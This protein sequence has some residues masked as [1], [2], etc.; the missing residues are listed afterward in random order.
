M[1]AKERKVNTNY[2]HE[3]WLKC[4]KLCIRSKEWTSM[5]IRNLQAH[6]PIH[7]WLK[8]AIVDYKYRSSMLE[9]S[10]WSK[11]RAT[12]DG[13]LVTIFISFSCIVKRAENIIA[14]SRENPNFF[15]FS[16]DRLHFVCDGKLNTL[17]IHWLKI[18]VVYV[19]QLFQLFHC[20]FKSAHVQKVVRRKK[21]RELFS[22]MF[23]V[24]VSTIFKSQ[25]KNQ[26]IIGPRKV[27]AHMGN[28][29][30]NTR[31]HST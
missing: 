12:C 8:Y 2:S 22:T 30:T 20:G 27:S 15:P 21:N 14:N 13:Q 26:T 7:T 31:T 5:W 3:D 16:F 28:M 6:T 24:F 23:Y 1:S 25:P 18:T 19:L 4:N 29:E 10:N 9:K 11:T 17:K